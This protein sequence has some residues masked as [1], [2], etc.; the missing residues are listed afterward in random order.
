VALWTKGGPTVKQGRWKK[1]RT[2]RK[3]PGRFARQGKKSGKGFI[4]QEERRARIGPASLDIVPNL[5]WRERNQKKKG[6]IMIEEEDVKNKSSLLAGV[7]QQKK[8]KALLLSKDAPERGG[9]G[10][11][12]KM[13]GPDDRKR[14]RETSYVKSLLRIGR[15]KGH[16]KPKHFR[17]LRT[18]RMAIA[19]KKYKKP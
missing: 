15:K 6:L 18:K 17:Y 11:A 19:T 2:R 14:S 10:T 4:D 3:G 9:A 12:G 8:K 5:T 16:E 1:Q 13:R 7:L